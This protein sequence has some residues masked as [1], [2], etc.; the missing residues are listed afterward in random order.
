MKPTKDGII[1]RVNPDQKE[2]AMVGDVELMVAT[3]YRTNH[4]EKHPVVG[5]VEVGTEKVPRGTALIVHHNLFYGEVSV[6]SMGD[7]LFSIPLNKNIFMRIDENGDPHSMFGNIICERIWQTSD[8]EIPDVYKKEYID[9]AKVISDGYGYKKGQTVFH[10]PYG[11]YEIVYNWGN[12]E[13]RIIKLEK[14]DIV[15]ISVK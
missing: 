14:E 13:R 11:N 6:F 8:L 9:R 7:G 2:R 10:V 4:R 15:A 12:I 3:K 1:L 5:I